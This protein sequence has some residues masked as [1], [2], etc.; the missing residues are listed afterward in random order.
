MTSGFYKI[1][2]YIQERKNDFAGEVINTYIF[3][4]SYGKDKKY[5][6]N[7]SCG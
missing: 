2:K 6:P 4:D 7:I 5:R 3:T 1:Q